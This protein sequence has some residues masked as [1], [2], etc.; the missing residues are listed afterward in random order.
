[1][2]LRLHYFFLIAGLT[3]GGSLRIGSNVLVE[4]SLKCPCEACCEDP[5]DTFCLRI[6]TNRKGLVFNFPAKTGG[7]AFDVLAA[8]LVAMNISKELPSR[9]YLLG[10]IKNKRTLELKVLGYDACF[11]RFA[12][13][14]RT[15]D[16]AL[17]AHVN[18][19]MQER[20]GGCWQA[21]KWLATRPTPLL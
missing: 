4:L 18:A 10:N 19:L 17:A 1:M 9:A 15:I 13:G 7:L 12:N 20:M 8:N 5:S 21:V 16:D 11:Q 14:L 2:R 6:R 3:L